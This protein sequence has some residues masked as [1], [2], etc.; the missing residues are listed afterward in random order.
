MEEIQCC[1][2]GDFFLKSPRHKQQSYCIK[3]ACRRAR[4]AAWKRK[5]MREDPECRLNQKASNK[6]WAKANPGYW[7]RYRKRNPDKA[8]RNRILQTLR[9]RRRS[10]QGSM[11]PREDPSLIAKVDTSIPKKI[12]VFGE[13]YMVPVI[14]KVDALKVYIYEIPTPYQ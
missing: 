5:K 13:F 3:P 11:D 9:N 4:K 6:Q 8:E 2:C 1:H 7:K 14:A 12:K 10:R